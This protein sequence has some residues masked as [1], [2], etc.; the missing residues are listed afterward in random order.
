MVTNLRHQ[1]IRQLE[2]DLALAQYACCWGLCLS[3]PKLSNVGTS[4]GGNGGVLNIYEGGYCMY[5]N[6]YQITC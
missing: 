4:D 6:T 1:E 5:S 3:Y 2:N